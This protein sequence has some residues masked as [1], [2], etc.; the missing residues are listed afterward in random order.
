[1]SVTNI[2]A[3]NS[4]FVYFSPITTNKSVA[5]ITGSSSFMI[6]TFIDFVTGIPWESVIWYVTIYFPGAFVFT[7]FEIT[8]MFLVISPSSAS[9]AVTPSNSLNVFPSK[10]S[11]SFALITGGVFSDVYWYFWI[12]TSGADAS[13]KWLWNTSGGC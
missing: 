6:V 4:S 5:W 12:N 3:I 1:M 7:L 9:F 8:F 13:K 11:M 2:S 10:S